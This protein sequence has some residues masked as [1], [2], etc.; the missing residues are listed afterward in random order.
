MQ[1]IFPIGAGII[2]VT[3]SIWANSFNDVKQRKMVY[4]FVWI[5]AAIWLAIQSLL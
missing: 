5:A 4:V 2:I 3:G 1:I